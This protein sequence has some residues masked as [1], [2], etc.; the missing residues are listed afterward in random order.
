MRR[1]SMNDA[2]PAL[3]RIRQRRA[4]I[5]RDEG[6]GAP[7]D[8]HCSNEREHAAYSGAGLSPPIYY[9]P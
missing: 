9:A 1:G 7:A 3:L 8:Y 5:G 6:Y 2:D 4:Q